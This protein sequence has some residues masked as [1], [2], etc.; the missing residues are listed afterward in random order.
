MRPSA[1]LIVA[2]SIALL[3]CSAVRPISDDRAPG[4]LHLEVE[5]SDAEVFIDDDFKGQV[6]GWRA[7]TIPV[8]PGNRRVELRA[9]GF[10]A[11]RFDI[12]IGS[13]EQV[14]LRLRLEK[15]FEALDLE[16]EKRR[17]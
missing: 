16:T 4:Y 6:D 15:E 3:N 14:T 10:L 7:Q 1:V 11:Q 13:G 5:P 17:R 8:E 2:L 9:D 12:D